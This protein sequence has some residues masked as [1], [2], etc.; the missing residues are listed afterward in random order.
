VPP[1]VVT[2]EELDFVIEAIDDALRLADDHV[3]GK[4]PKS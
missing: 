2:R 1:L 4:E 3:A